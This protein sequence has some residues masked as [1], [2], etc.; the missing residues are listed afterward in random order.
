MRVCVCANGQR[1]ALET[2]W[3]VCL[4][5]FSWLCCAGVGGF[6]AGKAAV[7]GAAVHGAFMRGARQ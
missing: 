1:A 4:C 2:C 7:H 5:K 3:Q 6:M